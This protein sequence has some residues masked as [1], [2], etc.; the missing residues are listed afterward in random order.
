VFFKKVRDWEA[1]PF[2]MF[3]GSGSATRYTQAGPRFED[4][5]CGSPEVL[6]SLLNF[7]GIRH[8]ELFDAKQLGARLSG[9][10][11]PYD[12]IY[13]FFAIGFH[14][15]IEHFLDELLGLMR[16]RSIGAFTLHNRYKD[17][18]ALGKVPHRVVRVDSSWPRGKSWRML[19][20]AKS[21]QALGPAAV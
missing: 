14:W 13:S 9:L 8:C 7:N 10:P 6:Q 20:M 21:E 11:G 12:F 15:S 1:V 19:V 2:H 18:S 4:S 5:F 3:E 16:D 17:L